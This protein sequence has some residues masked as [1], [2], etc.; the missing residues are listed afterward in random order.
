MILFSLEINVTNMVEMVTIIA[1]PPL[2]LL[3]KRST[4]LRKN[5][6]SIYV[7]S[8]AKEKVSCN[9]TPNLRWIKKIRFMWKPNFF[10]DPNSNSKILKLISNELV[11]EPC[12]Q[13]QAVSWSRR[14]KKKSWQILGK[15]VVYLSLVEFSL[16]WTKIMF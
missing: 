15:C 8:I 1:W 9:S 6:A 16:Y 12:M 4:K 5:L 3:N 10:C 11:G 14:K 7:Y 2:I 13:Y